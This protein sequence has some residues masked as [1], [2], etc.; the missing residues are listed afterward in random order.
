M[1]EDRIGGAK[2]A[3]DVLAGA[4]NREKNAAFEALCLPGGRSF[5]GLWMGSEPDRK[6]A[7][8]ADPLIDA[9]GDC[10]NLR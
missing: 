7:V 6:N 8:A 5:E 2:F 9:A 10:F 1:S 4:V 3:Y